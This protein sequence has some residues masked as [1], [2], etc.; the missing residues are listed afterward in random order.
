MAL[1]LEEGISG[2]WAVIMMIITPQVG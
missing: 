2:L 1:T